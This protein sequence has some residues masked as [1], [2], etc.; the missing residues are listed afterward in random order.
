MAVYKKDVIRPCSLFSVKAW[1]EGESR[2]LKKWIGFGFFNHL[3]LC[4]DGMARLYYDAEEGLVFDKILDEK[5]NE[6]LFDK[7]CDNLFAQIDNAKNAKT[8]E[9]IFEII[10][11]CW[12]SFTIFDVVSKYP[13]YASESMIRRLIRVRKETESFSYEIEER[14]NATDMPKDFIFFKGRVIEKQ[15]ADFIQENKITIKS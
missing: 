14:I 4:K 15:F 10:V 3:F 11:K 1:Y 12:P 2:E 9:E 5:L 8:E 13:E 6:E 7:L